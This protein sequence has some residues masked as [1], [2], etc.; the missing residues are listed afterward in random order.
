M[1]RK[2]KLVTLFTLLY[3]SVSAQ[4]TLKVNLKQ[5]DSL[6][7]SRNY[8]LLAAGMNIEAQRAAEIQAALY[9]NPVAS[10]N[11]NMYDPE[12]R[13][14][15]HTGNTGQKLFQIEQ[16]IM[17][18]GKRKAEIEL[19]KTVTSI[20][21]YEF[22]DMVRELK[23]RLHSGLFAVG[24]HLNLLNMYNSQLQLL[25][26]LLSNTKTQVDKGNIPMKDLVRL[27]G[28]YL[29]LNNDRA[30]LLKSY[31]E[32]QTELNTILQYDGPVVHTFNE[33]DIQKYISNRSF[34]ELY[35]LALDNRPDLHIEL[36]NR[37]WAE[38]N[39]IYQKKLAI[40]DMNVFVSYDQR[41]GAFNN[42]INAGVS[43]PLPL[44]NKNQGNV[45]AARYRIEEASLKLD[46]MKNRLSS[47]IRNS[48]HLYNQTVAEYQRAIRLYDHDFEVTFKGMTENFKKRNVSIVE[49]IDFFE[50]YN[51][52]LNELVRIKIQ[53]VSSG[54]EL[55]RLIGK[56][57]Y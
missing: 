34:P 56:D 37:E 55:N 41:S 30:E 42:E 15:L 54:E 12:N 19:A 6:F 28:A 5:A 40:P 11:L 26:S 32:I 27:K 13:K 4:D 25:D 29:T 22:Q 31:Y 49:F 24:Q 46:G 14:I 16:L 33:E 39:L 18:G 52:V 50:S 45:K 21:E 20:A 47:E 35:E 57:V 36:K 53:L 8:Y 17:L 48:H 23:Y 7:L 38:Q 44:W 3:C 51:E 1:F 10:A 43:I 9:P 2:Y